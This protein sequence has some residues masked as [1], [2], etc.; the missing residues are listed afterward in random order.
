MFIVITCNSLIKDGKYVKGYHEIHEINCAH[1]VN[2]M[3]ATIN[4]IVKNNLLFKEDD[5]KLTDV[6]IS[7]SNEEFTKAVIDHYKILP[8]KNGIKID[9][10]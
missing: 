10:I 5:T 2:Y 4:S 1:N 8:L 7:C 6:F 3:I 9:Y